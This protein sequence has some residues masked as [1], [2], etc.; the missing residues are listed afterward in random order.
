MYKD[1]FDLTETKRNIDIS[2]M[3]ENNEEHKVDF[4]ANAIQHIAK[5]FQNQSDNNT[6]LEEEVTITDNKN[7]GNDGEL[8]NV[9]TQFPHNDT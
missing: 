5:E 9:I 4:D 2:K 7:K 8:H 3:E 6:S 1:V